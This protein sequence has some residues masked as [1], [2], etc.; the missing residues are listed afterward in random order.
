VHTP[1]PIEQIVEEQA[2]R[3]Q[4]TRGVPEV[5][6][7]PRPR[8]RLITV[9]RE[10]GARG[11][12]VARAVADRLGLA[13]YDRE[14]LT[15]IAAEAHV[16]EQAVSPLDER[17]HRSWLSDWIA[18]VAT[19]DHLS[20]YEYSQHLGNVVGAI[21]SAGNAVILGR[22]AHLMVRPGHALRVLVEAPLPMRIAT[23]AARE[24][25]DEVAAR[26]RVAELERER[27]SFLYRAF[28][29]D[30]DDTTHFDLRVSTGALG[31]DVAVEIVCSAA[32]AIAAQAQPAARRAP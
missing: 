9:S 27:R 26:R 7:E 5:S 4:I 32:E 31:V 23:V 13:F 3:W 19:L 21:A 25:I 17:D 16:G 12:E 29:V 10:P 28:H 24:G 8:G 22:G 20:P 30:V 11:G 14:I 2:R 1:R 15:R 18:P 6:E